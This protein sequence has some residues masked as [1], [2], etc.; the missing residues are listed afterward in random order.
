MFRI[1]FGLPTE[2][3]GFFVC[4][5]KPQQTNRS[6]EW[7]FFV[8]VN[9]SSLIMSDE[10]NTEQVDITKKEEEAREEARDWANR[11]IRDF[12]KMLQ[13]DRAWRGW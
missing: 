5:S 13:R 2:C 4:S 11:R 12:E 1:R 8:A 7:A 9:G 6:P 3:R 10:E